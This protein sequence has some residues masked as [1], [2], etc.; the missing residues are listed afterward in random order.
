[1]ERQLKSFTD[2]LNILTTLVA[3]ELNTTIP[4]SVEG[5]DLLTIKVRFLFFL[6]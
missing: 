2:K 5:V 4:L 3:K 6:L 1:M